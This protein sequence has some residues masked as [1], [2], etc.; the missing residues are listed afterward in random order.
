MVLR[1]ADTARQLNNFSGLS[2]FNF[3]V[4]ASSRCRCFLNYT[5]LCKKVYNKVSLIC[6]WRYFDLFGMFLFCF[7][8]S[9]WP[10]F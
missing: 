4:F 8:T 10:Y 1:D 7:H 9:V 2:N 3:N 6:V 5:R